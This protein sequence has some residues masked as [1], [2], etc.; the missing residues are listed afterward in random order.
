MAAENICSYV[1]FGF[2]KHGNFCRRRHMYEK[3]ENLGCDGTK[4]N[5]NILNSVNTLE[6]TE[7]ANLA[8]TVLSQ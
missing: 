7:D 4:C 6:S 5:K 1:K 3:W 2:C 8:S